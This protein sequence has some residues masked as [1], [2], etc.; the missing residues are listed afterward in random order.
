MKKQKKQASV[1]ANVSKN[2]YKRVVAAIKNGTTYDCSDMEW[3]NK[4]DFMC[5]KLDHKGSVTLQTK[6]EIYPG[7]DF[8]FVSQETFV[9]M[10]E[11]KK[12]KAP[13][14]G[15]FQKDKCDACGKTIYWVDNPETKG[16]RRQPLELVCVNKYR[17]NDECKPTKID[18][19]IYVNH[20]EVSPGCRGKKRGR[21]HN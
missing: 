12:P 19:H 7:T 8:N 4:K 13:G 17:K 11:K 1:W 20:N 18:S 3:N 6:M 5:M 16:G 10:L 9:E 21:K 15:N 14:K 2:D